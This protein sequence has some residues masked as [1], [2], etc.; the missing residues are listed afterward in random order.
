MKMTKG[1]KKQL[2]NIIIMIDKLKNFVNNSSITKTDKN[3]KFYKYL[4]EIKTIQGNLSN[5]I[6]YISCLLAKEYLLKN[7]NMDSFDVS[8]KPQSANGLDI[9]EKLNNGERIICEIKTIFPYGENDFGAAQK[10]SFRNDFKKLREASAEYKILFVTEQK[11]YEI[12]DQKYLKEL[13]NVKI[14]LLNI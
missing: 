11:T 6:S 7:Y 3:K 9:D 4:N 12:L 8:L 13:E 1:E 5:S 2:N 10:K 14:V